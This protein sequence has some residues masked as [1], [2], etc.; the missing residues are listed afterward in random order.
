MPQPLSARRALY[1][2]V[3]ASG[4]AALI[5][6]VTWA[7]LIANWIGSTAAAQAV[8]L[9][10]FMFGLAAGAVLFGRRSDGGRSPV[11]IYIALEIAIALYCIALPTIGRAIGGMY[12]ASVGA[13]FD[14]TSWRFLLRLGLSAVLVLVPAVCM[15]GTLPVLVRALSTRGADARTS[16][17]GLY[18][19]NN[20]GAVSGVLLAGFVL[21]PALGIQNS[22]IFGA[23]LNGVAAVLA[24]F[25]GPEPTAAP[26]VETAGDE[27]APDIGAFASFAMLFALGLSGFAA[28]GYE[29]VFVR[30]IALGYGSSTYSFS[31]MLI[32]FITGLG[33][34]SLLISKVKIRR[35][36]WW[37]AASQLGAAAALAL[38]IPLSARL[39]YW[40]AA[41]RA[42][43]GTSP[44]GFVAYLFSQGAIVLAILL[45]P[46]ALIG[47]GFPLV[48]Y[49]QSATRSR[50][51][52][53]VGSTYA[54]NTI[55]NVLGTLITTLVLIP[56][57]G[58]AGALHVSLALQ[59]TAGVILLL[60]A[61][62][63]RAGER[64]IAAG[65]TAA[66]LLV[67]AFFGRGWDTT[68]NHAADHLRLREGPGPGSTE[69]QREMHPLNSFANWKKRYVIDT[70]GWPNTVLFEDPDATVLAIGRDRMGYLV[71]NNKGDASTEPMDMLNQELLAHV[72]LFLLPHAKSLC[73]V[74]YGSGVS[75][76]AALQHPIDSLEVVEI[77]AGVLKADSV[78]RRFNHNAMSDPRLA[79]FR[80]DARTFLRTT[81][82]TYDLILV[83][84]SNPWIAGIGS[85]FTTDCYREAAARL[86]PGGAVCAWFHHY[87]QS[88]EAIEL[89]MRTLHDVF[90]HV[91]IFFSY[92]SDVI[93]VASLE[94]I[95]PDFPAM[96]ARFDL[97]EVRRDLARVTFF[98]LA[99]LLAFHAVSDSRSS[100]VYGPGPL[101]TDDHQRLEYWGPRSLFYGT[102]ASSLIQQEGFTRQADGTTDSWLDRYAV[103][104][105]AQGEPLAREELAFSVP[106]LP[107]TLGVGHRLAVSVADRVQAIEA[108]PWAPTRV[109]RGAPPPPES[110]DFAEAY[111][112]SKFR[113]LQGDAAG[114]KAMLERALVIDPGHPQATTDLATML[115]EA[116]SIDQAIALFEGALTI[117]PDDEDLL[118]AATRFYFQNGDSKRAAE[119]CERLVADPTCTNVEALC[120][121]GIFESNAERYNSAV[122]L[123]RRVLE[124][125]PTVWQATVG[126][127]EIL[128]SNPQTML[129][130]SA[131][132]DLA[133]ELAP[134]NPQLLDLQARLQQPAA[135]QTPSLPP[136][137]G[138]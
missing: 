122:F 15:G 103:W 43:F 117:R 121:M 109:A 9:A 62:G 133:L 52:T 75:C 68:L 29:V 60:F 22:L 8:V 88:D 132:L 28:M 134:D 135:P 114:A 27:T 85:L 76:G 50:V 66:I 47:I 61:V 129:E 130:A 40:S 89:V 120:L 17:S 90:P 34:G 37:L 73:V 116:G 119:V 26:V 57:I 99:S 128:G 33:V 138:N 36:L 105:A 67:Y 30:V 100:Q 64:W 101:N 59:V 98:D 23:A 32:G 92:H 21:L 65:G 97:P 56:A 115:L 93:A 39:P 136:A 54:W 7:R 53:T 49:L 1:A 80:D 13:N 127:V 106:F 5:H 55:G 31:L 24:R 42:E 137:P 16:I 113:Q 77:S 25:A 91:Q 126:L 38:V 95:E 111:N 71:V 78:F 84:P 63:A 69:A 83:Q 96:E 79:V 41:L 131:L 2:A 82:K 3:F 107:Q 125:D 11:S 104:R 123:F 74:G 110:L 10:V 102:E 72:P 87:E 19:L 14:S 108:R 35:P 70:T 6:E 118:L 18:A 124:L 12:E 44:N 20:L 48:A 58:I 4:S 46:T 45:V 112:R 94:P 86:N 51:G 81:P